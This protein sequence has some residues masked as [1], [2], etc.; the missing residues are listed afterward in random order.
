M[1][2]SRMNS[3]LP[4][5]ADALLAERARLEE[6]LQSSEDWCELLRLKSRKDRGEGMSAVNAARLEMVLI[7]ALA[8][9]PNFVRYKAVCVAL[10]RLI[11]GL[12]P[13]PPTRSKPDVARDDLTQIRGITASMARRL[14]ALDVTTFTQIADWRAADIQSISADL[15][16][17][18]QIYAQN[19]IEQAALLAKPAVETSASDKTVSEKAVSDKSAASVAPSETAFKPD[20][21]TPSP[22]PIPPPAKEQFVQPV[23]VPETATEKSPVHLSRVAA[24]QAIARE[25]PRE[26]MPEAAPAKPAAPAAAEPAK[27]SAPMPPPA[28]KQTPPA[29]SPQSET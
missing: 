12:P 25:V 13:L 27:P 26:A 17:G 9:D 28:A 15:G 24:V 10:E 5:S 20:R 7:D 19:W 4:V 2:A 6:D 14:N 3:E 18:K 8:E 29:V 1:W 23:S 21:A 16:I 11:R 22:A